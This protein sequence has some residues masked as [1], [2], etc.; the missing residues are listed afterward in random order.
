MKGAFFENYVNYL[1]KRA[2]IVF[3]FLLITLLVQYIIV[4]YLHNSGVIPLTQTSIPQW[5]FVAIQLGFFILILF[6]QIFM[7]SPKSL[8][9]FLEKSLNTTPP[10]EYKGDPQ[11]FPLVRIYMVVFLLRVTEL[12]LAYI[13]SLISVAGVL[14]GISVGNLTVF[15]VISIS[16]LFLVLPSKEFRKEIIYLGEFLKNRSSEL[17]TGS[18]NVTPF[19]GS[20]KN[21]ET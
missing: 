2:R 3:Y 17:S 4:I 19:T 10:E 9:S 11:L 15:T 16:F 5:I 14:I 12:F 18:K 1:F 6:I 20:D 21:G 13:P 8:S 7:L